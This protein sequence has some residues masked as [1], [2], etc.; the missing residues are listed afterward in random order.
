MFSGQGSHYYHMAADLFES[1]PVFRDT[2]FN[3]DEIAMGVN[4]K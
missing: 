3:L 4:G 1:N 2:M